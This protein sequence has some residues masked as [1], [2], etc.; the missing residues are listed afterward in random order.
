MPSRCTIVKAIGWI[1]SAYGRGWC[2]ERQDQEQTP[3]KRT[4]EKK[5][6]GQ[7][8]RLRLLFLV[9]QATSKYKNVRPRSGARLGSRAD[10]GSGRLVVQH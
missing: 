3:Q 7:A 1:G 5:E 2:S 4:Q 10:L 9:L 6:G 8:S